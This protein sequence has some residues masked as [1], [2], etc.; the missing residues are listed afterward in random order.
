MK[1][2]ASSRRATRILVYLVIMAGTCFSGTNLHAQQWE[3]VS[4][5]GKVY[6]SPDFGLM[7]GTINRIEVGASVGYH[8]TE[9]FSAGIGGRYEYYMDS[10]DYFGYEPFSTH[11]Y[12]GRLFSR[13]TLIKN[14]ENLVPIRSNFGIFAH[15]EYEALSL[16]TEYYDV[17]NRYPDADRFWHHAILFGGG[18]LQPLGERTSFTLLA[19][20]NLNEDISSPYVNPILRVG[21]QI[22]FG[23]GRVY[24]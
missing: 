6:L 15:A 19:L 21:I 20:W 11:T 4:Y 16:E 17:A 22:Y 10:R 9:R 3:E 7:L 12:G 14:I 23:G 5:K 18:I 1:K 13:F 24:K 2:Y 8:L